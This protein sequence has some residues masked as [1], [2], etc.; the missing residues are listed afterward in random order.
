M[1]CS[2]LE[3]N[4]FLTDA[5]QI[6]H[7]EF[8]L[9]RVPS[10]SL[11]VQA[12]LNP[13]VLDHSPSAT[14]SSDALPTL[15]QQDA[16]SRHIENASQLSVNT[17]KEN[18]PP[19]RNLGPFFSGTPYA[20]VQPSTPMPDSPLPYELLCLYQSST[21]VLRNSFATSPPHTI[22][23]I[24]ELV[25][26]PRKHYR[27]LPPFLQALDRAVSVTSPTTEFP[28]PQLQN[29]SAI[30][31]L[32][33]GD[34]TNGIRERDGLGSDESLGGALLT[35]IPWIK[36]QEDNPLSTDNTRN[37]EMRTEDEATIDGPH[38]AGRIET[39][40]VTN[41]NGLQHFSPTTTVTGDGLGQAYATTHEQEL[42]ALG[43]V[44]HGELLRQEQQMG[45][46]PA[47]QSPSQRPSLLSGGGSAAAADDDD[48]TDPSRPQQARGPLEIG[49]E[50]MGPQTP[51]LLGR[52]LDME[53]A[54]G[55]KESPHSHSTSSPNLE[56][57][58]DEAVTIAEL[59]AGDPLLVDG[60]VGGVAETALAGEKKREREE[61]ER[62]EEAPTGLANAGNE[63]EEMMDV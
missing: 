42:R 48:A 40:S 12:S 22:Q 18:A 37:Q 11:P 9:P 41:T 30:N 28:L 50:D 63:D 6:V 26:Q 36:D 60:N 17:N 55:R 38:G 53:A 15:S 25:L 45:V 49:M 21:N 56:E 51:G 52:H 13:A 39:V 16:S 10:S 4:Q 58:H 32:T 23:R 57:A 54:V 44:T 46:I 43:G 14:Q 62:A 5:P 33:N 61:D 59:R 31:F 35:P 27:Y 2:L 8:P 34:G 20:S 19:N 29:T 1:P 3:R 47:T 7:N 24:A